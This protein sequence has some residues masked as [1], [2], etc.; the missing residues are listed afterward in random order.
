MPKREGS[1]ARYHSAMGVIRAYGATCE[2]MIEK[3]DAIN[4]NLRILNK[5]G[6]DLILYFTD[7]DAVRRDF[8]L[9]VDDYT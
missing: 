2:E 9:G 1:R 3:I 8:Q 7:F 4:K 5:E 6:E